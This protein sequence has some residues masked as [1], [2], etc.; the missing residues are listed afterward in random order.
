MIIEFCPFYLVP[1]IYFSKKKSTRRLEYLRSLFSDRPSNGKSFFS[2]EI[3]PV[4]IAENIQQNPG[5]KPAETLK[6]VPPVKST[7]NSTEN[8]AAKPTETIPKEITPVKLTENSK[9][10]PP[11]KPKETPKDV[12]PVKPTEN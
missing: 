11:A 8:P 5:T 6:D 2:I 4:N 12:P 1:F 10:N 9:E 7:N 3:K